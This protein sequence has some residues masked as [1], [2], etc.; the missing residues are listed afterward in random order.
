MRVVAGLHK[1]SDLTK[2]VISEVKVFK[3]VSTIELII[4]LHL[5]LTNNQLI[6]YLGIVNLI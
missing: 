5:S 6:I 3:L 4:L 1:R 2:A